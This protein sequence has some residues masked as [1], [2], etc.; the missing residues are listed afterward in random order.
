M[1]AKLKDRLFRGT[2]VR[3]ARAALLPTGDPRETALRQA[4]LTLEVAHRVADPVERL[5]PG[6]AASVLLALYRETVYWAL[7]ALRPSTWSEPPPSL[8]SLWSETPPT[9]LPL[10]VRDDATLELV[11]RRLVEAETPE[12]LTATND[13]VAR[14]RP[15]VEAIVSDLDAPRRRL[16]RLLGLRWAAIAG[17]AV[18][19]VV[20]AMGVRSL[21]IGRNLVADHPPRTS[22]SWAGCSTDPG[23][24]PL[25]FCTDNEN[26]PWAEFDLGSPKRIHRVDVTNRDD[27]CGDRA[28]PLIIEAS[29]DHT[30]WVE[31]ARRN[32]EFSSFTVKFPPRLA[33]YVRFRV[34]KQ[35]VFHLKDVAIR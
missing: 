25:L 24:V 19:L 12:P 34:P 1:L 10:T 17:M 23:C 5:P 31:V 32:E 4:K 28:V 2:D 13:D 29:T 20:I 21:V 35:T 27:C 26:N 6:N 18:V 30:T 15:F 14:L 22:T 8:R 33:R 3:E 11:R 7:L 9:V 16:D